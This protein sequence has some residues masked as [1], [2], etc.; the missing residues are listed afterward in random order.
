MKMSRRAKRMEK[1]HK[2]HKGIVALNLVSLMDIFTILVFFLLV[3]STEVE[4]LPSAKS[5]IL[6]E[7]IASAK[8]P[9]TVIVMVTDNDILVD[10]K[11]VVGVDD[12][13]NN[14]KI[15]NIPLLKD[16]LDEQRER[17]EVGFSVSSAGSMAK[18]AITIMA[19]KDIP[20]K[21]IKKIM[22][23]CSQAKYGKVSFAVMQKAAGAV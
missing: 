23:S 5:V 9:K 22:L 7:S 18:P 6:P 1:S 15:Y 8:P 11:R 20:Y 3:S 13:L 12:V 2:R 16:A 21:L 14:D 17:N 10:D 19:N 4:T